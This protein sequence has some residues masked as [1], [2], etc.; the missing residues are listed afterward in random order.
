MKHKIVNIINF[1]FKQIQ[2]KLHLEKM[3]FLE[4][5]LIIQHLNQK[6]RIHLDLQDLLLVLVDHIES[7]IDLISNLIN[8]LSNVIL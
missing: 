5:N 3:I 2:I 4:R 8:L 7:Y 6:L 1:L